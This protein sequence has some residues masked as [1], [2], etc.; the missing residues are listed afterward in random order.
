[1]YNYISINNNSKNEIDNRF[2]DKDKDGVSDSLDPYPDKN[3]DTDNDGLSDDWEN[4]FLKTDIN[5]I[6]T[7]GDGWNDLKDVEPLN[8]SLPPFKPNQFN[9]TEDTDGD[10][11]PDDNNKYRYCDRFPLDPTQWSDY[12]SDGQGDNPNGNY[13]DPYPFDPT[14]Y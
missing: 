6:D 9:K 4:V 3:I 1:M 11:Y 2:K 7:D 14:R 12:D 13:P 10:S 8:A 5:K